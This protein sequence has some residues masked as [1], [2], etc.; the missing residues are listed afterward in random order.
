MVIFLTLRAGR[1]PWTTVF[2]RLSVRRLP[3]RAWRIDRKFA[4]VQEPDGPSP[5]G[6]RNGAAPQIFR[7]PPQQL[8]KLA[9]RCA[10]VTVASTLAVR[11]VAAILRNA[12][13]ASQGLR[14]GDCRDSAPRLR[15][16][17]GARPAQVPARR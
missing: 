3:R 15:Y 16:S 6:V 2:G 4:K 17:A 10:K 5:P 12:Q 9:C 7:D 11:S 1:E 8:V 14:D 13:P